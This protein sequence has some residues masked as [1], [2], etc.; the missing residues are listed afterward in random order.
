MTT[1]M[2]L[3]ATEIAGSFA[4]IRF[5]C[6]LC[7][8]T[9]TSDELSVEL[10]GQLISKGTDKIKVHVFDRKE[11]KILRTLRERL[12]RWTT[13]AARTDAI[14]SRTQLRAGSSHLGNGG[15][16]IG[17][18]RAPSCCSNSNSPLEGKSAMFAFEGTH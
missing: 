1:S 18:S 9:R 17:L 12:R 7:E 11:A 8:N 2:N 16:T 15:K 6:D 13:T 5:D 4:M 10:R 3:S 14:P